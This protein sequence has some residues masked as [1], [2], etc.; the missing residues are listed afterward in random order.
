[1]PFFP[2]MDAS[3][4]PELSPEFRPAHSP[5]E[6]STE[7]PEEGPD[8]TLRQGE[9]TTLGRGRPKAASDMK[10]NLAAREK[11][12]PPRPLALHPSSRGRATSI[13]RRGTIVDERSTSLHGSLTTAVSV[14]GQERR[15]IFEADCSRH[16][17]PPRTHTYP[18]V[19][20]PADRVWFSRHEGGLAKRFQLQA[21]S[22]SA[23]LHEWEMCHREE[24]ERLRSQLSAAEL[25]AQSRHAECARQAAVIDKLRADLALAQSEV[26]AEDSRHV[27]EEVHA[28]RAEVLAAR[29]V[30]MR[31]VEL[32]EAK[33]SL[34]REHLA[35]D[36]EELRRL[37]G[38]LQLLA[39]HREEL[40]QECSEARRLRELNRRLESAQSCGV[41]SPEMRI[42]AAFVTNGSLPQHPEPLSSMSGLVDP[43]GV[44]WQQQMGPLE[45][46]EE[47]PLEALP[48]GPSSVCPSPARASPEAC[49]R[50]VPSP[51]GAL[52]GFCQW[53]DMQPEELP[54]QVGSKL[55]SCNPLYT[56]PAPPPELHIASDLQPLADMLPRLKQADIGLDLAM[57][58]LRRAQE[59]SS[60]LPSARFAAATAL[61]GPP[62]A[63][64]R[65]QSSEC[66]IDLGPLRAFGP[67]RASSAP[68]GHV[69][70][71]APHEGT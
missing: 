46:I 63:L 33:A 68:A 55:E 50:A 34:M 25:L 48:S 12:L 9:D 8:A 41:I 16:I 13:G 51:R 7:A 54:G 67:L 24:T 3:E 39:D 43:P 70:S 49:V 37:H 6:A 45:T 47:S 44:M 57:A 26:K 4:N 15:T 23:S 5:S 61:Y 38:T 10:G 40:Q 19:Q 66:N 11:P 64:P 27:V 30:E 17:T 36:S 53:Q 42:E 20:D 52:Q 60:A 1:M 69:L 14:A 22:D 65:R 31:S 62:S 21:E 28:W 29:A 2:V 58:D 32:V 59:E 18:E 35:C 56:I 71:M